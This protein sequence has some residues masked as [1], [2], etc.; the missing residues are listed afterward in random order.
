[1]VSENKK[2]FSG[3][4]F[5][6]SWKTLGILLVGLLLTTISVYF[7]RV[8]IQ[9]AAVQDFEFAIQDLHNKLQARLRTQA[10]ILRS[11]AALFAVSDS[12][13]REDWKIFYERK[14]IAENFPGI[15][16]YGYSKIIPKEQ[17]DLH[18]QHIRDEGF[19]DYK[20]IPPD[21]RDIYTSIIYLEPFKDRNL[22]AFGY[23][24][25]SEPVRRKAMEAARDSGRAALS[26]KVLLMQETDEDIQA[27]A[28]MYVPVYRSG[29][30]VNTIEERRAAIEGWVYS[31]YR[32]DDLTQGI[33]GNWDLPGKSRIHLRI[34][35]DDNFTEETLLFDSQAREEEAGKVRPNISA[36][37]PVI[38]NDKTWTMVFTRRSDDLT[39]LNSNLL[40]VLL[41]GIL[42]SVLLFFLAS[43]LIKT[44]YRATQIRLLNIQL[45]KLNADKSRFI[46]ILG[47]D[48]K[49]PFNRHARFP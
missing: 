45:E 38:F 16:G 21:E 14:G 31:P 39:L 36:S 7:T 27:G 25:F 40:V 19:P 46:S 5:R 23:D 28:L 35:D 13:T 12:I 41:S 42:I 29:M 33:L 47:H 2:L 6:S 26:G 1:M 4:S 32:I 30:P 18:I 43:T 48:L 3:F 22:R 44:K 9:K 10:Q 34:Y 8:Y 37:I 11:G 17:L 24:M 15:Q 49:N 20:I